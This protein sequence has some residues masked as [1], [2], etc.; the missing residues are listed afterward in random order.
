[1]KLK[2]V[3][4]ATALVAAGALAVPSPAVAQGAKTLRVHTWNVPRSVETGFIFEPM[5]ADVE[6]HSDNT[7]KLQF[8]YS[9][10][11]GGKARDLID[12]ATNGV[13]DISYTLPGYHPGRFAI[14][15]AIELPFVGGSGE[16]MSKV[17]WDW[18]TNQAKS[19]LQGLKLISVNAIDPGF[20]HTTKTP[21]RKMEDFKGLK[22]R[23]AGRYIGM[24][25]EALGG[26]PVQM[27]L[28]DVY[29][30]LSRGQTQGTMLPWIIMVTFK[31]NEVVK[32]HT[33]VSMYNSTLLMVMNVKA[34]ESLTAQQKAG[35][36]KSIGP[37]FGRVYGK[38]W[39]DNSKT[40]RDDA[41]RRGNE[42]IKLTPAEEARWRETSKSVYEDWITEVNKKGLNGR[43]MFN[44]LQ[45]LVQ[46]HKAGS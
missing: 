13:V 2:A 36:D 31:I 20:V 45:A 44:E 19:E 24:A 42:I 4:A 35:I 34:Y 17:A 38:R 3:V 10:A 41:V 30:S 8:Y 18:I 23:V 37:E 7:L 33:E 40:S 29:E 5:A 25:V 39:D 11:L 46:K 9:M 1:M 28:T 14:L 21:I 16:M 22:V 27:P 15:E 26:A 43:K 32:F 12:Q 6:K